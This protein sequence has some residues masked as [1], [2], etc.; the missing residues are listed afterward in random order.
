MSYSN[1]DE[2]LL[3]DLSTVAASILQTSAESAATQQTE[4]LLHFLGAIVDIYGESVV[5]RAALAKLDGSVVDNRGQEIGFLLE[6]MLAQVVSSLQDSLGIVWT[7]PKEQGQGQPAFE[8]R[9]PPTPKSD[10]S[11]STDS[12]ASTLNLLRKCLENC[13]VFLLHVPT[14]SGMEGEENKIIRRAV[15][16]AAN[17]L[18]ADDPDL[19][20][21]SIQF[22]QTVVSSAWTPRRAFACVLTEAYFSSSRC[23]RQTSRRGMRFCRLSF[24]TL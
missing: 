17:S 10:S 15:D 6:E 16:S 12:L 14:V 7:G 11:C 22:L 1:N 4:I 5:E 23:R 9:S 13:P 3:K 20:L 21:S 8:S 19:S 18:F 2:A 24:P